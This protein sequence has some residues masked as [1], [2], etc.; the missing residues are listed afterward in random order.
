M[1]T[2]VMIRYISLAD[3]SSI[4]AVLDESDVFFSN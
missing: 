4:I 3:Y 2:P 1:K